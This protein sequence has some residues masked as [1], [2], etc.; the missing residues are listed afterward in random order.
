[1]KM[2][3]RLWVFGVLMVGFVCVWGAHADPDGRLEVEGIL[4]RKAV[5]APIRDVFTFLG[6][7]L[8]W[9]EATRTIRLDNARGVLAVAIG[10]REATYFDKASGETRKGMLDEAP[11]YVARAGHGPLTSMWRLAGVSYTVVEHTPSRT[12]FLV[13]EKRII[14]NHDGGVAEEEVWEDDEVAGLE[15][16]P[17]EEA[18]PQMTM[19]NKTGKWVKV[20]LWRGN[21]ESVWKL[22]PRDTVGPRSIH[23]GRYRYKGT[24]PG[25]ASCSGKT[26]FNTYTRYTWTW[27]IVTR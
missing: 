13:G 1:M 9:I 2:H 15:A 22:P 16:E 18:T 4:G 8:Q 14:V 11:R 19:V 20:R 7:R 3:G 17:S 27:Y 24:A 21:Q 6:Y 25:V 5:M 23:S 10:K 12:E 26:T